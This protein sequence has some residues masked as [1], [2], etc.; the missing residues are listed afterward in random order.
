MQPTVLEK[1]YNRARIIAVALMASI[2]VYILLAE[3]ILLEHLNVS[4]PNLDLFRIVLYIISG[5]EIG[6]IIWFRHILLKKTA[7]LPPGMTDRLKQHHQTVNGPEDEK[8]MTLIQ[9][10]ITTT[11]ITFA[12]SESIAIYGL[13][14]FMLGKQRQDLYLL[15]GLALI[16]MFIFFPKFEDWKLS[17]EEFR[18]ESSTFK[19]S[20]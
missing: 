12:L 15:A 16:L 1:S 10:L 14:L 4:F 18:R 3:Y 11:I 7:P 17:L 13:I 5:V 19:T 2:F 8:E 6:I 9:R 20:D